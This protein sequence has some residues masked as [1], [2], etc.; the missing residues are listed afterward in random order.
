MIVGYAYGVELF[1]A[2]YGVN[3]YERFAFVN[4]VFGPL[5]WGYAIMVLCNVIVPQLLWSGRVR[6]NPWVLLVISILVN[7]GMWFER[8]VI[9]VGSL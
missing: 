6:G 2:W 4:R 8:F 3:F 5:A 1:T 7:V 9:I